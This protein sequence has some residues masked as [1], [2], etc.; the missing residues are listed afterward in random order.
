MSLLDLARQTCADLKKD[1]DNHIPLS[2][3]APAPTAATVRSNEINELNE[4]SLATLDALADTLAREAWA[5][6]AHRAVLAGWRSAARQAA[7]A[8]RDPQEFIDG[9]HCWAERKPG[10]LAAE[11][12]RLARLTGRPVRGIVDA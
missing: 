7:D 12:R 8:G 10:E 2:G 6:P 9:M 11:R 5:D 4:K 3:S 1:K